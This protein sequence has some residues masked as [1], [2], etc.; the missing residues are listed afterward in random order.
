MT[1]EEK[2]DAAYAEKDFRKREI[3]IA[4]IERE[5]KQLLEEQKDE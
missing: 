3:L 1:Y 5:H 4:E 2:L